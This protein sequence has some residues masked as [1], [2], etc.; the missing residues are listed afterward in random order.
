MRD[1]AWHDHSRGEVTFAEYVKRRGCCLPA[2]IPDRHAGLL[3]VSGAAAVLLARPDLFPRRRRVP[4]RAPRRLSGGEPAV[5]RPHGCLD[6][7]PRG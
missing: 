5:G 4:R 3:P 1:G 6:R 7:R 2:R